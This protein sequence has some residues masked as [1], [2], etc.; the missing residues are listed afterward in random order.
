MPLASFADHK[1]DCVK[2]RAKLVSIHS[3]EEMR[4]VLSKQQAGV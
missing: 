2:M 4:H 1:E 3:D